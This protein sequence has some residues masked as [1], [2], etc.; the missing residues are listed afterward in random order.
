MR[1]LNEEEH[2]E[3]IRAPLIRSPMA[4]RKMYPD[5]GP[6]P[7]LKGRKGGGGGGGS[8]IASRTV[9]LGAH[10]LDH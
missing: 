7:P 8:G 6:P 9:D 2:R 3:L 1:P 10:D 4:V 5:S